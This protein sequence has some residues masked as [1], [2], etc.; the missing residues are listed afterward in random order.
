M[1]NTCHIVVAHYNEDLEWL[2]PFD[3]DSLII[4]SKGELSTV[5][6][7]QKVLPNVGREAHTYL[8]YILEY[9]DNLPDIVFFTQGKIIDHMYFDQKDYIYETF[10][11]IK[12]NTSDNYTV[13]HF[14][15]GLDPDWHLAF[16]REFL[17]RYHLSGKEFFH[18]YINQNIDLDSPIRWYGGAIFSVRREAILMRS[19][20]YYRILLSTVSNANAPET[21]H[22]LERSWYY[23]FNP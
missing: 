17:T 1:I 20:E 3:K 18:T 10:L 2:T 21:A 4:Y 7:M 19:K 23:I 12:S 11:T 8:T 13:E 5:D 22:F 16:C 9:Y 6:C 14:N 15:F